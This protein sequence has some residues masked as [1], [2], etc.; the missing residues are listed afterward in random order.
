MRLQG[1]LE[2]IPATTVEL[3]Q[4]Q[5]MFTIVLSADPLQGLPLAKAIGM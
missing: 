1:I 5:Q 3:A 4:R 2:C